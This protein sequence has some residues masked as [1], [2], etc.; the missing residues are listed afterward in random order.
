[1]CKVLLFPGFIPVEPLGVVFTMLWGS[2]PMEVSH[3]SRYTLS[4][5]Y[6][7]ALSL[8]CV[9]SCYVDRNEW[10]GSAVLFGFDRL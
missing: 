1:M 7:S 6:S 4:S 2:T 8:S 5:L 9:C 3:K 10:R